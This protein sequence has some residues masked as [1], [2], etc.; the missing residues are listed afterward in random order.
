[1]DAERLLID[2]ISGDIIFSSNPGKTIK[3]WRNIFE[4]SQKEISEKIGVSPSVI[5]DYE[6]DRR[7]SP[8][9]AFIRKIISALISIDKE[10]GYKTLSKYKDF[11]SGFDL[12]VIIDMMEYVQ[13]INFDDFVEAIDGQPLNSYRKNVNG[14]T[15]VDSISAI[16]K[17][18]SYD[19]YKLY[20]FTSERALIFTKVSSGRSPM[21]AV[22]VSAFKPALIVLHGLK[23]E[24]VDE[25]ALKISEVEKIPLIVSEKSVEDMIKSLR[26]IGNG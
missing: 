26:R 4:V 12:D 23:A 14:Y 22:R 15:I 17:L 8:G 9:I 18:S 11:L 21:V 6:S 16:L 20:G 3:K 24:N 7:K 5:S 13:T 1:M 19:F 10:R 2:K 25:I